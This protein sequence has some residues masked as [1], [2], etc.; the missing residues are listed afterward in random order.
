MCVFY[1]L[2]AFFLY[3]FLRILL[4]LLRHDIPKNLINLFFADKYWLLYEEGIHFVSAGKKP[5]V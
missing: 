5:M 4:Y 1:L 3:F 2:L